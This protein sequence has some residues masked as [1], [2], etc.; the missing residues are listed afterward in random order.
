MHGI[1]G[2]PVKWTFVFVLGVCCS[3][4]RWTDGGESHAPCFNCEMY[5]L[6][7]HDEAF[8][9]AQV[10]VSKAVI[11]VANGICLFIISMVIAYNNYMV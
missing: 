7:Q 11:Y 3:L 10:N 6:M 8:R 9:N 4:P 2:S 1:N 5:N